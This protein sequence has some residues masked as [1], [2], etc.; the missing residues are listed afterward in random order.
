[1]EA[2]L[3]H[4]FDYLSSYEP[5]K[6]RKGLRQVEGLL[7]QICLS[8]A[9][10]SPAEKRRSMIP[11]GQEQPAPKELG[12]LADDP[13]FREFFKLQEGF[14]WNV[15]L[16]LVCCLEHL[17]GRGSNGTN[18]LLIISTLD[19][20]QGVL[21]L[22]P[23]SRSL[24]AR[25]IYMNILLDLLDPVNCPAIQ[26]S[27]LLTLVTALLDQPANTRTFELLD[28]LL[29]VTSLFKMRSTSREVKLKLV[30]FLYFY[31][32][33]ETP[34]MPIVAASAPNTAVT[35]GLHR[36]PSKLSGAFA[37]SVNSASETRAERDTRSTEEKQ[38]LLGR[39][40]SNVEDLVEDLKET[41][42]FG[43]TVY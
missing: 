2:L 4:S 27:T 14:Q 15:S 38:K 7:A 37:R 30:E 26:S 32:M 41:A 18:D 29:T 5:N 19:L 8:R 6:I 35:G 43:S 42:P 39:Y 34:N 21:L 36:S 1:M 17:L 28:G 3:A 13:A 11:L 25:E 10:Q 40:L 16:R 23:P 33:P 22:H 9:K 12:E 24:F 20:I 31:L